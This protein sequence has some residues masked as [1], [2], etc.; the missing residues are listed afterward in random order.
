MKGT[1]IQW[2]DDT[3]NP[4]S[5]C[6][7]CELWIPSRGGP[8]YAGNFHEQRLA[9]S[10][11]LLYAPTFEEV[12]MIPGRM[13]KSARCED[14]AGRKRPDKPWLDGLRRKI[15]VGDLGDV[16]SKDVPEEFLRTE[17]I[18]VATS[19]HGSRHDWLLLTK[20][21]Q[22]AAAFATTLYGWPANVWVGTSITGPVTKGRIALLRRVPAA[23]RFLSLEPLVGDPNLKAADLDGISWVIVG[24]ESTQGVHPGRPFDPTWVEDIVSL[25][26]AT[27]TACFVK[28]MGSNPV[29]LSL[30]DKHGGEW[31]EWPEHLRVRQ[32]PAEVLTG[33]TKCPYNALV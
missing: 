33:D 3:V 31:W 17:I 13:L 16:F 12:R 28:Q 10:L 30:S 24:G 23:V 4:T 25:C 5:G 6:Q 21:P 27:G 9:K 20:Q 14:Y 2:A 29:G 1:G 7:G 11:P 26:A 8:C 19:A 18:A 22:R 32:M 15:F